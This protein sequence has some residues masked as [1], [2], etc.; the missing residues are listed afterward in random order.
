MKWQEE[1]KI[2]YYYTD[3]KGK[4]K[5]SYISRYMQETANRSMKNF[6]LSTDFLI[7]NNFAFILSKISF[8]YYAPIFEDDVIKVQTWT[9]P[10]K[11]TIFQRN[12][13]IY[14]SEDVAVEATS[15]WALLNIKERSIVRPENF[16]YMTGDM[17]DTEEMS[18]QVQRRL[19]MPDDIMKHLED[20]TV[21]YSDIDHNMHMNNSV[22]IDLICDCI[23]SQAEKIDE[24]GNN[25]IASVNSIDISYNNEAL[26][27]DTL[28]ITKGIISTESENEGISSEEHCIKARNKSNDLTCFEAV[29]NVSV[30]SII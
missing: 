17:M 23:Y 18:F 9:L 20:Y 12:Y 26:F 29:V 22:Y 30:N 5:P 15:A 8:K 3:Y 1:Y 13:R 28:E 11:T 4:L 21:K 19:K 10:P 24:G 7:K 2:H 16:T 6:G 27:G 25:K 14:K